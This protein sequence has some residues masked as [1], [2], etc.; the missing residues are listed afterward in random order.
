MTAAGIGWIK[1]QAV[2][3]AVSSPSGRAMF[4]E[5]EDAARFVRVPGSP[6]RA[7]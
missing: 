4:R 1:R 2:F 5:R 7:G 6:G 3:L